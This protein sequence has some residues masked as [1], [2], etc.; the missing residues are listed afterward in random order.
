MKNYLIVTVFLILS[1]GCSP[2]KKSENFKDNSGRKI[3]TP[4]TIIYAYSYRFTIDMKLIHIIKYENAQVSNAN[5]YKIEYENERP[6]RI[7]WLYNNTSIPMIHI[8]KDIYTIVSEYGDNK[9]TQTYLNKNNKPI[10]DMSG[11]CRIVTKFDSAGNII[12]QSF[13]NNNNQNV[14]DYYGN[15]QYTYSK[16]LSEN[17]RISHSLDKSGNRT[18]FAEGGFELEYILDENGII[19]ENIW[20]DL[21]GKI[22]VNK[23]GYAISKLKYD[24]KYQLIE[25]GTY[26]TNNILTLKKPENIAYLKNTYD[27]Y[28]NKT[29]MMYYDVNGEL[30]NNSTYKCAIVKVEWRNGQPIKFEGIDK[31]GEKIY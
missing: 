5:I 15:Y 31:S 20:K 16:G 21:S 4:T 24:N 29:K 8:G 28:G 11:V 22:I 10:S 26:D 19:I 30:T 14:K 18:E 23:N 12:L 2:E 9:M 25:F 17:K 7:T 3:E 6:I 1:F 13:F 27:E